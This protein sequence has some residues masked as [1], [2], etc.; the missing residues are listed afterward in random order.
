MRTHYTGPCLRVSKLVGPEPSKTCI[1]NPPQVML[2]P[3]G[4]RTGLQNY[5]LEPRPPHLPWKSQEPGLV[6]IHCISI[7][8]QPHWD[9]TCIVPRPF[10]LVG[11]FLLDSLSGL[12]QWDYHTYCIEGKAETHRI[13]T[14]SHPLAS[15][16]IKIICLFVCLGVLGIE[17]RALHVPGKCAIPSLF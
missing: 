10:C 17:P 1:S 3:P 11:F 16:K 8:C 6:E 9:C 4:F 14:S 2:M 15:N 5:C 13:R 12:C 7:H